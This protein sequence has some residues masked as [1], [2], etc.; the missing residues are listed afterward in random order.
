MGDVPDVM[1]LGDPGQGVVIEHVGPDKVEAV[2]YGCE[3]PPRSLIE[4]RGIEHHH[5]GLVVGLEPG[6]RQ[7]AHDEPAAAG[8]QKRHRQASEILHDIPAA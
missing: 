3:E 8:N 7:M 4:F 5:A 6:S 1:V 2:G